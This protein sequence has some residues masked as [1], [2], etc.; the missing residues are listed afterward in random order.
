MVEKFKE[1]HPGWDVIELPPKGSSSGAIRQPEGSGLIRYVFAE[2]ERG[3]YL[4][5]YSFHRIWGDSHV[6]IHETGEV[7]YLDTLQTM[8]VVTGDKVHDDRERDEMYV[9][10]QRLMTELEDAGLLSGGPIPGSFVINS[11][12]VTGAVD[13]DKEAEG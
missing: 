5:Y 11:A 13:P 12:I 7:E 1:L 4:E 2:N 8:Y 3:M 10:N 9:R 6:R